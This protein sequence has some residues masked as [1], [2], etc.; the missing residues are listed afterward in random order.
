[1]SDEFKVYE[2]VDENVTMGPKTYRVTG[3]NR[4]WNPLPGHEDEVPEGTLWELVADFTYFD[5]K[6]TQIGGAGK[7]KDEAMKNIHFMLG[8]HTG[9]NAM[10]RKLHEGY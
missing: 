7:T 5:G 10:A 3:C 9:V 8:F 1:M 2:E 4:D 6:V